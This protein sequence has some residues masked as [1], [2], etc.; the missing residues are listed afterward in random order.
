MVQE[1][2]LRLQV[3]IDDAVLMKVPQCFDE[4]CCVEACPPL[5]E[6]LILAQVVKEL[7]TVEEIHDKVE[8]GGSLECVM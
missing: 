7:A 3:T 4:L 5:A 2:V 6:L 8:L 1:H